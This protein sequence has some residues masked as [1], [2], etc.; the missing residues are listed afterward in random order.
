M[1][2]GMRPLKVKRR[3]IVHLE[4]STIEWLRFAKENGAQLP[5]TK[6]LARK[7]LPDLAR[8]L[9]FEKWPHDVFRHT[10]ASFLLAQR[11]DAPSVALDLGHSVDVLFR[12]YRELVT[13]REAA[14]FWC[15]VPRR[16]WIKAAGCPEGKTRTTPSNNRAARR[17][18]R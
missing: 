10:A 17:A 5:A 1:R 9:G 6:F 2:V 4:P 12:H 7:L 11:Q 3:R 18:S 8:L 13:K 16:E 15:L 14:R